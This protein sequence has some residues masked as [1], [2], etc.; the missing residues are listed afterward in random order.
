M[1]RQIP[2]GHQSI[3]AEDIDTVVEVLRSEWLTTGP[4]VPQFEDGLCRAVGARHA[5]AVNSGTSALDIAVAALDLPPGSEVI[6]TPFTFAATANAIL[7]NGCVPVFG[8]IEPETRNISPEDICSRITSRTRAVICVDYAGHPCELAEI[9]E[10]AEEH[11]LFLIDDACHALGAEYGGK[12]LGTFADM[13]IFSFHPVKPITTGEGGAVVTDNSDLAERLRLLRS[14][15]IDRN[16]SCPPDQGWA[17]DMVML[18]RNYR[19]TDIQAA[20]G[21]SQLR[22]LEGFLERRNRIAELYRQ[23]LGGIPQVTLP[24][25]KP[26]VYHGWHLFTV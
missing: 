11:D 1:A 3:D 12:R 2:Y 14:H 25:V 17:Y 8:D 18:G 16:I 24:G 9:R 15:G 26:G 5:I 13:T 23:Q 19:L 22:R 20:L 7:Y 6:T 4:R 10:I 21:G